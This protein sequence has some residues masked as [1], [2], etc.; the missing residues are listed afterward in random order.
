MSMPVADAPELWAGPASSIVRIGERTM[1]QIERIGF[2]ARLEA[3]LERLAGLGIARIRLPLAWER[4]APDVADERDW[5]EADRCMQCLRSL[6]IKPIV[7]LVHHGSGPRYTDLLDPAFATGLAAHARVVAE[8]F[9]DITAWAPVH[10]PVTTARLSAL[11]GVWYPQ[12]QSDASFVRA[13][14]V[15]MRAIVLA[16]RAVRVVNPQATLLQAEDIGLTQS[17]LRLRYH[18][19]FLN[20]RRWLAFDL[21]CGRVDRS[22]RMWRYLR[23]HGA[24]E[25]ELMDFVEAP[26]PPDMLGIDVHVGSDRFLDERLTLYPREQWSGNGRHRFIDNE[27]VRV[28]GE[29]IGGFEARLRE[30]WQRYRLPL[31]V[32]AAPLNGPREEQM[33]WLHAA[34]QAAHTQRGQGADV[35]AVVASAAFG[36][37]DLGEPP[38]PERARYVPG[39]WDVRAPEPRPTALATMARALAQDGR[40]VH[41][42]LDGPGWWQREQRF[43]RAPHGRVRALAVAGRPLLIAGGSGPLGRAFARV[44]ELRGLACHLPE[45][46]EF[47]IATAESIAAAFERWRPWAVIDAAGVLRIDASDDDERARQAEARDPAVLAGACAAAGVRLVG[48]SSAQVFDGAKALPYVESDPPHPLGPSGQAA[49]DAER[50]LLAA[51][52]AALV[53]RT[54]PLFDADDADGAVARMTATLRQRRRFAAATDR[55]L[56]PTYAPQLAHA[57]LDLLLDGTAGVVHLANRGAATWAEFMRLAANAAGL[58]GALIDATPGDPSQPPVQAALA[59]ERLWVM[60]TLA[61]AVTAFARDLGHLERLPE[62]PAAD[63]PPRTRRRALATE[64]VGGHR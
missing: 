32:S 16:M 19:E 21:L 58:D 13:V 18:A 35:R 33:R 7:G 57:A 27:A 52:P 4:I 2:A 60:P 31:A 50:R 39:L 63:A 37:D 12:H 22:H 1:D 53:I 49:L 56:S 8:R 45:A 38:V 55:T 26:C 6:G 48:F 10:A 5:R 47:D 34:W 15:Q 14:L 41:P 9:P 11:Q 46:G 42:V 30:A 62:T 29:P 17:A 54:G 24:S 59:S 40:Y 36:M 28:Q 61:D 20:L 3:D 43:T 44:C 64:A 23:K 25:A 51:D